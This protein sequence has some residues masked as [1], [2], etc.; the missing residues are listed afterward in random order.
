MNTLSELKPGTQI[1]VLIED[2]NQQGQGVGR[3]AGLV[4]FVDGTIP[5]DLVKVRIIKR[6]ARYAVARLLEILQA[7]PDRIEPACGLSDRCGGCTLQIM[8]YKGQL[9]YKEKQVQAA[10][11]R[12]GKIKLDPGV[13]QPIIGMADPWHYRNKAQFPVAGRSSQPLI[14]FYAS[15]SHTVIDGDT[16]PIQ[17]PIFDVIR[18]RVR[19][20]IKAWRIKPY[21]EQKRQGLL[22]HLVIRLGYATGD[23]MVIFVING[24]ELPGQEELVESL[25]ECIKENQEPELPPLSLASVFLNINQKATNVILGEK[26]L[27]LAGKPYIEE[28]I[29]GVRSRI[30][31]QTFF[32][33][34]S[35]QTAIL[36][37]Q[38]LSL[39]ALQGTE[40]VL[41]LYC[42]SG[43][44]TL[45]LA[46]KAKSVLGI[47]IVPAAVHDAKEN[48]RF[49]QIYN[50]SFQAG[51]AEK[52]LPEIWHELN[53]DLVVL[54]PPRKGCE[55]E[56]IKT[57]GKLLPT[58]IIY[59]SCNPATLARD[60]GL[61]SGYGYEVLRIQP[62][63]MFPWTSHVETVVLMSRKG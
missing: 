52:I 54:D 48:A 33:I 25:H 44:I 3:S 61:L 7:S 15:R 21:D 51:K 32:Q 62:V 60:M 43:A 42:G 36:Y 39:A 38:I 17:Y 50:V 56:V 57:L 11:T 16:C 9:A 37:E 31:P 58:K 27:L 1:T 5:Q 26:N 47:E 4:I 18:K 49:N 14:G 8:S 40:H 45:Q 29:M 28:E 10:L 59:V 2:L 24:Q 23:I 12:I 35:R 55:I 19:Q 53:A 22:R 13:L 6:Q 46:K 63:D 20:H 30:S 41:D 34:N